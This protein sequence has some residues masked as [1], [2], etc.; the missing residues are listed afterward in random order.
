MIFSQIMQ[1]KIA[2]ILPGTATPSVIHNCSEAAQKPFFRGISS[3]RSSGEGRRGKLQHISSPIVPPRLLFSQLLTLTGFRTS[4]RHSATKL[5][6]FLPPPKIPKDASPAKKPSCSAKLWVL[7]SA[8]T[9]SGLATHAGT[10]RVL[11]LSQEHKSPLLHLP[12]TLSMMLRQRNTRQCLTVWIL[13]ENQQVALPVLQDRKQL[14]PAA[15]RHFLGNKV[16]ES[17][18]FTS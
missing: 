10:Y 7:L 16:S 13:S 6:V 3:I 1:K 14:A 8:E 2:L 4:G 9:D 15:S 12:L 11:H 18:A 17:W 5:Q